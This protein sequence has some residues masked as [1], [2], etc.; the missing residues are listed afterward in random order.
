[1]QSSRGQATLDR[2]V[3]KRHAP[4]KNAELSGVIVRED[5]VE[6][7]K[8]IRSIVILFRGMAI[9]LLVLMILQV[10]FGLTSTVP[11]SMGVV[12]ADAVRLIIFAGLLWGGGDLAV[13]AVKSHHDLRATRILVARVD[14][15]VRQI[16][17]ATS[18]PPSANETRDDRRP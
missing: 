14:H 13:L 3:E 16:G 6:P 11:L 1:M 17:D 9:I 18:A 8:A 12:L 2:K 5:D 15:M 7:V 4:P 10:F